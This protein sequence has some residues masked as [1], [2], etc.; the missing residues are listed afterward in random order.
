VS[1]MSNGIGIEYKVYILNNL[2]IFSINMNL[3]E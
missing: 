1:I 3:N 2:V